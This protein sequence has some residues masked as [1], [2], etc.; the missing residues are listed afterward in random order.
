V[1]GVRE[2]PR[3]QLA[4]LYFVD[5]VTEFEAHVPQ[6]PLGVLSRSA[7]ESST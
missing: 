3:V 4:A 5:E 6:D 7:H 1:G 2:C